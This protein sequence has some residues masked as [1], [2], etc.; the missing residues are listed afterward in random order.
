MRS[1]LLRAYLVPKVSTA[2]KVSTLKKK[3]CGRTPWHPGSLPS[4][5]SVRINRFRAQTSYLKCFFPPHPLTRRYFF[6]KTPRHN[7]CHHYY[8]VGITQLIICQGKQ[9][10]LPLQHPQTLGSCLAS[11][12]C[13]TQ[14]C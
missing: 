14:I 5:E 3:V 7:N 9:K 2:V 13:L 1:A 10:I 12:R 6:F 4:L 8:F 11:N